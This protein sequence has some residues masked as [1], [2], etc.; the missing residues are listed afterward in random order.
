MEAV[1]LESELAVLGTESQVS[2]VVGL[3][4]GVANVTV[5]CHGNL[6]ATYAA[7]SVEE[8]PVLVCL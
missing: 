5:G 3:H 4:M 8:L 2:V 1:F 6:E 7:G